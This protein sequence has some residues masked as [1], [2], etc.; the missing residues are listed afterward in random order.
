MDAN[1]A[2]LQGRKRI[3]ALRR[4]IGAALAVLRRD[5]SAVGINTITWPSRFLT[6]RTSQLLFVRTRPLESVATNW[7]VC[8]PTCTARGSGPLYGSSTT[9]F[10]RLPG[11]FCA[12]NSS[13]QR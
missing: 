5:Y 8:V 6:A 12:A 2:W 9:N 4:S 7:T 3:E 13:I 1:D 11:K 10:T